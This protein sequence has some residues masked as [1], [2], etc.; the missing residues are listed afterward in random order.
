MKQVNPDYFIMERGCK[1]GNSW[2]LRNRWFHINT[3]GEMSTSDGRE[4][5]Q[6]K[7]PI[8][9]FNR[10][11]ELYNYGTFNRGYVD[12]IVDG[13]KSDFQGYPPKPIQGTKFK[14]GMVVLIKGDNQIYQIS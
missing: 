14:D 11:I 7:K 2:S 6:A 3:I 4:Y 8:I 5:I 13:K 9:C 12:L 10:D 1:D